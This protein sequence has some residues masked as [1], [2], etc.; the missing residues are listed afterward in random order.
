MVRLSAFNDFDGEVYDD[1][2]PAP[3]ARLVDLYA[4]WVEFNESE[5][6]PDR[7]LDAAEWWIE[8]QEPPHP[9]ND[10]PEQQFDKRGNLSGWKTPY[11]DRI[12]NNF[13]IFLALPEPTKHFIVENIRAGTPWRGDSINV[14]KYFIAEREKQAKDPDAYR[15]AGEQIRREV[16]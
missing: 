1:S 13:R 10:R 2:P 9:R 6:I 8:L 12:A 16:V 3:T 4:R 15:R 5:L 14:Y 7:P 11:H